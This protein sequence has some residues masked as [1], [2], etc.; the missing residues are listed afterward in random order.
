LGEDGRGPG[1]LVGKHAD[2]FDGFIFDVRHG[3]S[4]LIDSLL[5]IATKLYPIPA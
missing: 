5:N 3:S 4:P 2:L 1:Y